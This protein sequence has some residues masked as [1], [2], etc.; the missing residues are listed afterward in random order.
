MLGA[1]DLA[2]LGWWASGGSSN[3]L[4]AADMV[5]AHW[6][7]FGVQNPG[8]PQ[9]TLDTPTGMHEGITIILL[10]L[11]TMLKPATSSF[12]RN[13]TDKKI[14]LGKKSRVPIVEIA[15]Q[16]EGLLVF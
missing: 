15:F 9:S 2:P 14:F 13:K 1:G 6:M 3:G 12:G 4:G 8:L 11:R 16:L 7:E 10:L 5:H